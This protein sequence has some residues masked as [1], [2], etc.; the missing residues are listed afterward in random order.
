[1]LCKTKTTHFLVL[2]LLLNVVSQPSLATEEDSPPLITFYQVDGFH[3]VSWLNLSGNSTVA[4]TSIEITVWNISLPDQ[5]SSVLTSQFLDSVVPY[6]D[7]ETD[8]TMWSW[9]QSFDMNSIDCTCYVEISLLQQT[10][11]ISFGLVVYVG[12]DHHRPVLKHLSDELSYQSSQIFNTQVINLAFDYLLPPSQYG[13]LETEISLLAEV[14]ICP[15]PNAICVGG[16][17]TIPSNNLSIGDELE[18]QIDTHSNSI[19]EGYYLLQVQIQ[20][21]YLTL[22]NNITQYVVFD[23]T[24]PNVSL[25]AVDQVNE[26]QSIVVDIDVDD[27][28]I[29][30][31][32]VITWSI[33][34]PDGT[35]RAVS[36]SELLDDNRLEFKPTKSGEYRVNALVRDLGGHLVVVN[37]NVTVFNIAPVAKVR[38]DGF[39]IKD[40]STITV[41]ASGDWVFSANTSTDSPNDQDLLDFYWFVDG[42]TLLSGK[43]YLSSSD[44]Q[45]SNYREIRIQVVDDDGEIA[46]LSFEVVQQEAEKTASSSNSLLASIVSILFI[47]FISLFVFLRQRSQSDSNTG[48]VKWTERGEEPKK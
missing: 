46:E 37:H 11:L 15:A 39:L 23:Q 42:K 24:V 35:P 43:S 17:T 22:S 8:S 38:Y 2:C 41:P 3:A 28:Y 29:G 5:W 20:D 47:F 30:S 48:F 9:D 12:D 19:P 36:N 6:I 44:I 32:F 33:T 25:T 13:L 34:E 10:D 27:G 4:L 16:Y 18:L 21:V 26:S 45:N 14:R 7:S 1:M 40:G 31:N